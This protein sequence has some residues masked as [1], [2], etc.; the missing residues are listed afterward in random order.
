LA[1][2]VGQVLDSLD[3]VKTEADG[4]LEF[5]VSA[6]ECSGTD[7]EIGATNTTT[8]QPQVGR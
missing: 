7:A 3:V 2:T 1:T 5:D 6:Y 4:M 8:K